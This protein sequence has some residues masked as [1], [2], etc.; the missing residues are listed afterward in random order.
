MY[1]CNSCKDMEIIP[2]KKTDKT[3]TKN[4]SLFESDDNDIEFF[5]FETVLD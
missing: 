5:G 3:E 4:D 2:Y 1:S